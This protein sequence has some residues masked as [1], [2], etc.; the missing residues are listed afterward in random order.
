MVPAN[1]RSLQIE[2]PEGWERK[3]DDYRAQATKN[4]AA[5]PKEKTQTADQQKKRFE[6]QRRRDM[7]WAVREMGLSKAEIDGLMEEEQ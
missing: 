3:V 4:A 7:D 6:S 5:A 2:V 1:A